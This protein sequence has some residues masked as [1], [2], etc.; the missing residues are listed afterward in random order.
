MSCGAFGMPSILSA[1]FPS[2]NSMIV[3]SASTLYFEAMLGYFSVFIFCAGGRR[4]VVFVRWR[5][6]VRR[7]GNCPVVFS[8]FGSQ[9][10]EAEEE[11]KEGKEGKEEEQ[12]ADGKKA[13]AG[14]TT[15]FTLS[16]PTAPATLGKTSRESIWHGPHHV[17]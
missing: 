8:V 1:T 9:T 12:L 5:L 6:L 16:L 3:G 4:R 7:A 2:L 14:P 13:S 11:G 15:S 10:E 17:A